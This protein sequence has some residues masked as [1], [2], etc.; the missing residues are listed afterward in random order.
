MSGLAGVSLTVWG[1]VMP[2][3]TTW[4]KRGFVALGI[5]G[6]ICIIFS[7]ILNS[8]SQEELKGTITKMAGDVAKLATPAKVDP[9]LTPD[10]ILG[11][12]AAKLIEQ[13]REIEKLKSDVKDLTYPANGFYDGDTMVAVAQG[14]AALSGDQVV[15]QLVVAR[16]RGLDFSKVFRFQNK[17]LKCDKPGTFGQ[18]GT[19]GVM[20]TQYPDLH[21]TVIR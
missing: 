19:F 14:R 8:N 6:A 1:R 17:D 13:N 9:T 21:C 10:Q 3:E 2:P 7:A 11:A 18:S 15:F 5:L 12:A 20:T 4:A 16:D